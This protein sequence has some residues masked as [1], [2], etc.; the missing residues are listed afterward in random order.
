[1][2]LTG[3][4]ARFVT[5]Y[6]NCLNGTQAAI[7]AGYSAKTARVIA[8]ENLGKPS[9]RAEIAN[10]Q[11]L[12]QTRLNAEREFVIQELV[13]IADFNISRL[14]D[15]DGTVLPMSQWPSESTSVVELFKYGP[16]PGHAGRM[17]AKLKLRDRIKVL[18]LIGEA[19]GAFTRK[20]YAKR[21]RSS[22]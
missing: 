3:K 6:V 1:M 17:R 21:K 12:R 5:E 16:I 19:V 22:R 2:T 15:K 4:Q 7:A 9:I 11:A 20:K 18:E 13:K 14:F 8:S 10:Q